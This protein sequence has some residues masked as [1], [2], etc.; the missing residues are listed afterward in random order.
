MDIRERMGT[1]LRLAL[2]IHLMNLAETTYALGTAKQAGI[3]KNT[4]ILT[5]SHF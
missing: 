2:R 4:S 3:L 1:T 5:H